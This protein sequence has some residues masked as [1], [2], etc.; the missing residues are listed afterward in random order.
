[1]TVPSSSSV[2]TRIF[3]LDEHEL[4]RRGVRSLLE[5]DRDL[6][7]VGEAAS[8][9]EA[10]V[11]VPVVRPDVAV[12]DVRLPDGD[13]VQLCRELRSTDPGLSCLLMTSASPEDALYDAVLAGAAG[14]VSTQITGREMLA[15]IHTVAGGG[16]LLARDVTLEQLD[17]LRQEARA[18]DPLAVLTDQ[19]RRIFVLIAAGRTNHEIGQHLHLSVKTVKNYVTSM[20][21]KLG[22]S[23]RT[24]VAAFATRLEG[25]L[26]MHHSSR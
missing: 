1:V 15:A 11:R 18:E 24:Q 3:V 5:D 2:R 7:V 16:S 19:E 20:F 22:M 8:A 21:T 23:R 4:V 6:E 25:H 26:L 17:G 9:A 14:Y 13:G 12:L 10:R